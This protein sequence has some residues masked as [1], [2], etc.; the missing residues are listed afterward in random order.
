MTRCTKPVDA[1]DMERAFQF[2]LFAIL[3]SQ[4]IGCRDANQASASMAPTIKSGERVTINYTAY[5]VT[6]PKRWDVIAFEPPGR[7][8]EVWLKRVVGLPGETVAFATGGIS[9]NGQSVLV[10]PQLTNVV[11][12]SLDQMPGSLGMSTV[13][14][15]Y[16][17]PTASYF[18][19]GDNSTNSNDSRFWG[20]VP[21]KSILGQVKNK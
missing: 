1:R 8:N 9:I 19:L 18:V 15:P 7:K 3:M 14:S 13:V 17:V 21:G 20:A 12:A 6:S 10:P 16:V 4:A 11:Y 5:S 2:S